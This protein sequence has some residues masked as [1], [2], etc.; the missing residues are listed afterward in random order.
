MSTTLLS[1]VLAASSLLAPGRSHDRLAQA[2]TARV[3]AE[4]P[5]FK[6]DEDRHKTSALLVAIAFRESS[7]RA[8]A[9]GDFSRGKP[10]SFCAF[11]VNLPG[12]KTKE[13]W[14]GDDL[15]E[16]PDK[17]VTVAMRFVRDS[18]RV[19]PEHPIAWY[20]AGPKG[21][22]NAHAQ[23]ISRDRVAI[24]QRLVR[25]VRVLEDTR[26]T[27]SSVVVGSCAWTSSF[28]AHSHALDLPW[29][30]RACGAGGV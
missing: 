13:G 1:W 27:E 23:R 14:T 15:L 12:T 29:R 11:Q 22:T 9:V 30:T 7:L 5:L 4:A 17:C 18:M 28:V 21:C 6:N 3:E 16:D 19:C 20:A 2:I 26:A 25:E 8:N 10:T 24:A